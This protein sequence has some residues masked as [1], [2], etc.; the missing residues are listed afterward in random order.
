M[1]LKVHSNLEVVLFIFY[2]LKL[3]HYLHLNEIAHC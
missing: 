3:C 2:F 1:M